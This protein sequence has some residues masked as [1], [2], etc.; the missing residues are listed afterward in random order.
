MSPDD[1]LS[2]MWIGWSRDVNSACRLIGCGPPDYAHEALEVTPSRS[3][4]IPARITSSMLARM[5]HRCHCCNQLFVLRLGVGVNTRNKIAFPCPRCDAIIRAELVKQYDPVSAQLNSANMTEVKDLDES[6]ILKLPGV[7]V[8]AD[9]PVHNSMHGQGLR[10]GGSAFLGIRRYVEPDRYGVANEAY[11]RINDRVTTLVPAIRQASAFYCKGKQVQVDEVITNAFAHANETPGGYG[12]AKVAGAFAL[13]FADFFFVPNTL[14]HYERDILVSCNRVASQ[15]KGAYKL[16]LTEIEA[17]NA[18]GFRRRLL[19]ISERA[20]LCFDAA[21]PGFYTEAFTDASDAGLADFRVFRDDYDELKGVY[22]D[23]F[24]LSSKLA[25]FT[26]TVKNLDLRATATQWIDGSNRNM[27][28]MLALTAHARE[29]L[30]ASF[31]SAEPILKETNRT[32]R[33]K[34][35]HFNIRFDPYSGNL[36]DDG[37][38]EVNALRFH[39]DFLDVL[40]ILAFHLSAMG[41]LYSDAH[42][43]RL[44]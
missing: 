26:A 23:S 17:Q 9:I 30:A 8:Y 41:R 31:P 39:E 38:V 35:G 32:V 36:V 44:V 21:I 42:R 4:G 7:N 22:V 16:L 33:N 10:G 28:Q 6:E 18:E 27:A 12:F 5:P 34:F 37:L 20:L 2:G 1:I 29:F 25:V 24:E 3:F 14:A 13:F 43:F 40:R 19:D 15:K 11:N